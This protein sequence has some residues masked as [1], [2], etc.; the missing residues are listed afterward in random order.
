MSRILI[1]GGT[2]VERAC[3]LAGGHVLVDRGRI[4]SHGPWT[5]DPG[6]DAERVDA[7]GLYVLPGLVDMHSDA[8]EREVE[9][10]P[11]TLFPLA[12]AVRE[13]ERRL[14]GH[15]ITTMFHSVSIAGEEFGPR[16]HAVALALLETIR[17]QSATALIRTRVHV[18]YEV[19]DAPGLPVVED[20]LR[21]G[22]IHLLSFMDHTPGQGQYRDADAYRDYLGRVYG[23]ASPQF[24]R[25]LDAKLAARGHLREDVAALAADARAMGVPLASHDDDTLEKV[26][27]MR[28]WGAT[29]T[30]FPMSLDAA[31]HAADA[32][33]TVCVGAPNVVRG[34]ST[35]QNLRAVDAIEAGTAHIL[36]SD[37]YPAAL[38][39]AVFFLAQGP[40]G[41][42]RA[43]AMATLEA[44]RA[45]GLDRE[46]GSI[47]AGK[48]ADLILV[49]MWHGLPVVV[50]TMVAGRWVYRVD[51]GRAPAAIGTGA[52]GSRIGGNMAVS[53]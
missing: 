36:C 47:E 45:V 21:R 39:H 16:S 30:E 12:L 48:Q 34:A 40:L 52:P 9:P 46:I 23:I 17:E 26:R 19:T 24:E 6:S 28:D 35:G 53:G 1:S 49:R 25:L 18:R 41:L 31:R 22:R 27:E 13:M 15:G 20:L 32:G 33:M 7:A 11:R 2:V 5:P 44:A 51:Y 4:V 43:V 10:R 29:I 50:A 14:A 38:L 37:Y 3:A 8:V 42:P